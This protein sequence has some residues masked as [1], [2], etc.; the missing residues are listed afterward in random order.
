MLL[1]FFKGPWRIQ[2]TTTFF[3][4][5]KDLPHNKAISMPEKKG[6][7]QHSVRASY[8]AKQMTRVFSIFNLSAICFKWRSS[9]TSLWLV[10]CSTTIIREKR[11]SAKKKREREILGLAKGSSGACRHFRWWWTVA[12]L[13]EMHS[14]RLE[15]STWSSTTTREQQRSC[16]F[17]QTCVGFKHLLKPQCNILPGFFKHLLISREVQSFTLL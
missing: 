10:M 4:P 3:S 13:V 7:F 8:N 12:L 15:K 14:L 5:P 1:R 16:C 9:S 11:R 6:N 2:F 17:M